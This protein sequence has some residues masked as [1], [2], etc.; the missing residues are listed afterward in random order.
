MSVN[1]I[2]VLCLVLG[3]S[4]ALVAGVFLSFSDFVMSGLA[5]TDGVGGIDAMQQ[6]NKTVFGSVFLTTFLLMVPATVSFA[7]YAW[8]N[9]DGVTQIFIIAAA[10]IY[11]PAVFL[12]TV[13]G[14]VPMN[15]QLASL[16]SGSLEA[17][18]YWSTYVRVWTWWNHART[19]GATATATCLLFAAVSLP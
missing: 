10:A 2:A 14:N 17:E 16:S 12:V 9:V 7:V 6:I 1:S 13:V 15:E 19:I 11:L 8:L 3:V 4:S 5:Q 18:T